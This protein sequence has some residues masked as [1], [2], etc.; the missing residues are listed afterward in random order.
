M[1]LMRN[2]RRRIRSGG[3]DGLSSCNVQFVVKVS[4][5]SYRFPRSDIA[6]ATL[7]SWR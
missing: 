6:Y 7:G 4:A 1:M 2:R 3:I 5:F